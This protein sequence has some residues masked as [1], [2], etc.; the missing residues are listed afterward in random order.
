MNSLN[1]IVATRRSVRAYTGEPVAKELVVDILERARQSPSG[2]NVQPW[3][4]HVL[5]NDPLKEFIQQAQATVATHPKGDGAEFSVYPQGLKEPYRSRRYKCGEDLYATIDIARDNKMGRLMQLAQ[6]FTFF[7]APVG[8]FFTIDRQMGRPQWAHLG[9]FIQTVM[10]LAEERGL[11]TCAQEAWSMFP[12]LV[13]SYLDLP[14]H[15]MLY[16]GMAL[17]YPDKEHPINSLRTD[18]A[19]LSELAQ[20]RGFA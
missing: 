8:L 15:M 16:C 17:G 11:G 18:R 6:N 4:V 14:A 7:G 12:K 9:M 1:E 19:D 3:H 13:G 10:L 2:G 20:F 5:T